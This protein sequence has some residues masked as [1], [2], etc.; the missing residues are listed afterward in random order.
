M[1]KPAIMRLAPSMLPSTTL[2]TLAPSGFRSGVDRATLTVFID[3]FSPKNCRTITTHESRSWASKTT[4]DAFAAI[5][6]P[7]HARLPSAD[8]LVQVC[9]VTRR[10]I[11]TAGFIKCRWLEH[12]QPMP[13]LAM[14]TARTGPFLIPKPHR[15]GFSIATRSSLLS[16]ASDYPQVAVDLYYKP[17]NLCQS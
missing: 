6:P 5:T 11:V 14:T 10:I 4:T 12:H 9:C 15:F 1:M 2:H 17:S 16:P 8:Y 7:P 13:S 3:L